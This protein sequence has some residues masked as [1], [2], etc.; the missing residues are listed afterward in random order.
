M[1]VHVIEFLADKY[2]IPDADVYAAIRN[3]E[4]TAYPNDWG[5]DPIHAVDEWEFVKWMKK[6]KVDVK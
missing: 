1:G 4:L 5:N 6:G 2:D 3:G